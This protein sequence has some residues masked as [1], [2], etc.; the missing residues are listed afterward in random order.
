MTAP[1][2]FACGRCRHHWRH[3]AGKGGTGACHTINITGPATPA[4]HLGA[5]A[6]LHMGRTITRCDCARWRPGGPA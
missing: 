6:E 4:A 3:H 2:G 1:T 5:A